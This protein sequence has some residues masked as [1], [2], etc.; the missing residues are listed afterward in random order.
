MSQNDINTKTSQVVDRDAEQ[1]E[2]NLSEQRQ[3]RRDKLKALQDADRNPFV[4]E[5]WNVTAHSM[6]IKENFDAMEDQEVSIAGRI[7]SKRIMGKAAF[8][9]VQD[10][11]GRIQAYIKRDDIGQEDYKWF[12]TYDIGDI[13]GVVGK[14]FKTKTGEVSIHATQLVLMSKSIQVLPDKWSGL[15]DQ[16][17]RYRQRYVDLIMNADVRETFYKRARIIKEIKSVLEDDY[18]F[19]EVDTPI[20][21]TIAGGANARPFNTY[22]NTLNLDMKLRISNELFLKRLIELTE[23][24]IY[25]ATMAVNG[26]PIIK[27]QGKEFDVT[28]PWRRLDMADAVKEITGVDFSKIDTDEEAQEAAISKGMKPE[29]VKG[30]TRGKLIAEMFDEFCEDVPGYLDGPVF[31]TGHPVDISPLAKRDPKD[32]RITRRFEFYINGWEIGNAF[33]EL[34]DPIDQ[35]NRFAEQQKQLDL[36]IDD[37]AHPMDMDF[38]NALEVGMPPTGGLGIGIDRVIMLIA[39]APS[40]RDAMLFPTM[41]PI[42]AEKNETKSEAVKEAE[43]K[44]DF[45][46]VKIEPLFEEMVD[47]ETFSKS[48]FRAV[49][50]LECVAVPKSKK[51]LQFTLDDGSGENRTILSGIHNFYEPE[52][53]VGKTLLAITNLPPRAMMGI[54]SCG[55]LLSAIHDEEGEEQ[56]NLIMLS[57]RIPAG[58]KLY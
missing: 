9:D 11:Q 22:H 7:M 10:K 13:V 3:I 37:E 33:S 36:G 58:A 19:L 28:P 38:V 40:I 52:E 27:Y 53:L 12:K 41:K 31:I 26:T 54:E 46:K 45:S 6:D 57:N 17:L 43:E 4:V 49:K 23:Q 29:D 47:F 39:D 18:G 42:G 24:I 51:L 1:T 48:D 5:K 32:P 56:L 55:M 21:T 25:K 8:I 20:L 50:V 34:N 44:I 2:E 30:M 16:D 35:Y 15:Q 14:V